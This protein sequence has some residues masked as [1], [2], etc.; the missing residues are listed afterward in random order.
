MNTKLVELQKTINLIR[1]IKK[2]PETNSIEWE[3]VYALDFNLNETFVPKR[4]KRLRMQ[5]GMI[6]KA[7]QIYHSDVNLGND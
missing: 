5:A 4:R 6:T 1:E 7:W 3:D 2:S